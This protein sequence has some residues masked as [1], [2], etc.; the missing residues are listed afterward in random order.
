MNAPRFTIALAFAVFAA[1]CGGASESKDKAARAGAPDT[2]PAAAAATATTV[3]VGPV[4]AA[5]QAAI[6]KALAERIPKMPA[7][8]E[9]SRS[10]IAGLYE[11][12]YNGTEILYADAAGDH[13]IVQG[14]IIETRT[15][16]DLTEQR[17]EKLLAIDFAQLPLKD[18]IV[19]KQGSGARK[20][21]VFV[22]PNCGYCKRFERDLA[23]VKDLTVYTFLLPILGPDS[24][25]K[26]RA[27]WCAKDGG[28]AWRAWMLDGVAPEPAKPGCD[29]A[30]IDRNL[31]FGR[32]HRINGTPA[33]LFED[34]TRKPGAIPGEML[35]KL[36][37]Q[38][39]RKS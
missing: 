34:G 9:I 37:A 13:V 26:S 1:A 10:P 15:R 28:K 35:E 20:V 30:G 8:D 31:E 39:A 16:T 4:D 3:T 27:I 32:K 6:R 17:L 19:I 36:L 14:A 7:I 29:V 24:T 21:A 2:G 18:A 38:A 11:V 22:D 5:V 25:T 33:V 12:R 23:A